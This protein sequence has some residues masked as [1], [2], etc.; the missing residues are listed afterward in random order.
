[1][2]WN[3]FIPTLLATLAGAAVGVWAVRLASE[4][5]STLSYQQRLDDALAALINEVPARVA[6]LEKWDDSMAIYDEW[7][8]TGG[9]PDV[10][11]PTEPGAHSI[12]VRIEAVRLLARAEDKKITAAMAD[13]FAS[14]IGMKPYSQRTRLSR[15][16]EMIRLWRSGDWDST[17]ATGEFLAFAR[18]AEDYTGLTPPSVWGPRPQ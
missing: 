5:Q 3:G 13:A 12:G 17:R 7:V 10:E 15:L 8:G 4:W 6:T 18:T 2:D 1:M 9:D 14:I 16:P 11:P